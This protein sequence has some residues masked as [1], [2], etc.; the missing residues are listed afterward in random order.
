MPVIV[1]ECN[2]NYTGPHCDQC[3]PGYYGNPHEVGGGCQATVFKFLFGSEF[4]KNDLLN[5]T[6]SVIE[7]GLN[8]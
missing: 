3:A 7:L 8:S 2:G 6:E 5:L 4:E 1:C